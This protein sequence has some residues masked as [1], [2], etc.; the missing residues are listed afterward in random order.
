M[1]EMNR[2]PNLDQ[3]YVLNP[4]YRLRPDIHRVVLY[5]KG[6][7]EQDCSRHW[8]TFIHPLHAVLLSFFTYKRTLKENLALLSDFFSRPESEVTQWVKRF[9]EN[10]GPIQ[11]TS[12]GTIIHFP[13]R[14]LIE[15][16]DGM[17][18]SAFTQ[19]DANRF[20]WKHL[21]LRT[22]RLYTGPLIVTLMLTNRCRTHCRYCYADT[23]TRVANPLSTAR[24]L[25]LIREAA[26]MEVASVNLMGGEVFL[27][28]DWP[29]LLQETVKL[30]ME[31]DFLSTK[32][33]LNR[34][35]V[36]SLKACGYKGVI[37]V[38][39]DAASD[40]IV[41]PL[42]DTKPGY[43]RAVLEGLRLLDESGLN[44]Q[45]ATVLT[46]SNSHWK[47]LEALYEE[48]C[49]LKR[50]QDWRLVPVNNS[51]SKPYEEFSS[52]KPS[53]RQL[54]DLFEKV[55]MHVKESS[56]FPV[57]LGK[58]VLHKRY[59][60]TTGG[61]RC[62][63]GSEC[64]ALNSHLFVLPDGKVTICEQLYWN[65]RF[66]IG[67]VTSMTLK[68]IWNSKKARS[69]CS[70][71]QTDLQPQS[72]CGR[73]ALFEQCFGYRNRCWSDIIKAYG[74]DCWDYPDPRCTWAPTM[75]YNLGYGNGL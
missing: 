69:L 63:E 20:L 28:P 66:L 45:V 25:E 1:W 65:P 36:N 74:P 38:S 31:P 39:L 22:R 54:T 17:E 12:G 5:A 51:I 41:N 61:S 53:G 52:L 23:T 40:A 35:M 67:D 73:C 26:R 44:Y 56:P 42:I 48:L 71:R 57:I 59:R 27:H 47:V 60:Q 9:I 75:K 33:P 15:V 50:L 72:P 58:D 8:C 2:T 32:I 62:F 43:V 37:Q 29:L 10:E 6:G 70:L 3:V 14:V 4:Y 19:T 49:R 55:E 21:D 7:N 24:W 64:S 34:A 13:K 16:K 68:E 18:E 11:A 30:D 46:T